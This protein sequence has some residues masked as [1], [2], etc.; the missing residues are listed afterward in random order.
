MREA[1]AKSLC[2]YH[3]QEA[4]VGR[5]FID[6]HR[7]REGATAVGAYSLR[8]RDGAAISTPVAWDELSDIRSSQEF[9]MQNLASRLRNLRR[10]HGKA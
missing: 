1:M 5:I 9:T 4:R 2:V 3:G 7:N 8:A 6:Y 10:I